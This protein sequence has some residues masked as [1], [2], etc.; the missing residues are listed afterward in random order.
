MLRKARH[1][2]HRAGELGL[3]R[4][5]DDDLAVYAD[6][7][8]AI[9]LTHDEESVRRRRRNTFGR[10]L[11]LACRQWEAHEIL[12]KHLDAAIELATS[13]DAIVVKVSRDGVKP[14][15]TRWI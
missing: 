11:W 12:A 9:F 7:K 5:D 3:A 2:C 4:A 13:R 1:R 15:D 10:T 6:D 8:G 14:F